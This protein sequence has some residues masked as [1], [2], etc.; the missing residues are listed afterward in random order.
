MLI[1]VKELRDNKKPECFLIRS[2]RSVSKQKWDGVFATLSME[3][4]V[5]QLSKL[6][7][8]KWAKQN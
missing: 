5:T 7:Y 3:L 2:F 1:L 4:E 6:R 8:T